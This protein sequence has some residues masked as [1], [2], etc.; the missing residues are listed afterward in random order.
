MRT[1][2]SV[3]IPTPNKIVRVKKDSQFLIYCSTCRTSLM[4][5]VTYPDRGV[6]G[7]VARQA[8]YSHQAAYSRPQDI[9]VINLRNGSTTG[10]DFQRKQ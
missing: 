2:A 1:E 5:S 3:S 9:E 8:I 7:I 4:E 10:S 6:L